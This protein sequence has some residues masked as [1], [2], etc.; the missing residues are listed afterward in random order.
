M[1]V[2]FYNFLSDGFNMRQ[3]YLPLFLVKL[4]G[5]IGSGSLI[6]ENYFAFKII[7]GDSDGQLHARD[8]ADIYQNLLPHDCLANENYKGTKLLKN[9]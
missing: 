8:L 9:V 5:L 2:R 6:E 4:Y 3:I 1:A 7:D